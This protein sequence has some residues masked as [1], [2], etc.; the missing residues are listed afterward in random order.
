MDVAYEEQIE[1]LQHHEH[2]DGHG[3]CQLD[4]VTPV[5]RI[6]E[7]AEHCGT[8]ISLMFFYQD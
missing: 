6:G 4:G 7:H 2:V 3:A 1:D 8:L 5:Y